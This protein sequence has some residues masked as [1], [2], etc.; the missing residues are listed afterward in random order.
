MNKKIKTYIKKQRAWLWM[1]LSMAVIATG[2]C[3][4]LFLVDM[5]NR[6]LPEEVLQHY[7][8]YVKNG[9]YDKMY[10]LLNEESKAFISQGDFVAKNKKI[11][12][13][14]EM[15][16]LEIVITEITEEERKEAH[17]RYETTMDT[18]VGQIYFPNKAIFTRN[19]EREYRLNW[20]PQLIFPRLNSD[21]KVRVNTLKGVRGTIYDRNG[22][23]LAGEGMAS[24]IGIVPGKMSEN[25]AYDIA[26]IAKLLDLPAESITK[27][28]GESYVKADTFVPIKVVSKGQ[29]ELESK[30]LAIKGIKIT[31]TPVR[32]YPLEEKIGHLVGYI[33]NVNAEDLEKLQGKDYNANSV[34]GRSGLEKIYE[35]TL[36]GIDG[37][38]IVIVDN[39]NQVK[40]TLAKQKERSEKDIILTIDSK[41][42]T[43]LYDQFS[44]D[45]SSAV[46]MNPKTG[47][48]LALVSTPSFDSNDFVLGMPTA[49]WEMLNNDVNKPLYNRFK[50]TL[51]PGSGFKSVIGA[52][53]L[54]T[55]KLH[56]N[57]NYGNSGL[58]WQ[59]DSSWGG[60]QVTTLKDYGPEVVLRNALIYSDN[61]YFAKAALKIGAD[62][63]KEQLLRLGFDE[64]IPFEVGLYSSSFSNTGKFDSEIQL[65]DS[66]YGQ[67]Q[68]LVNPIHM[69]SIYSAFINEGNMIKPYLIYTPTPT[70][71]YWKEQAFTKEAANIIRDD[72]IQVVEKAGKGLAKVEGMTLAGKTG[73]AEIKQSKD[74]Y[75]GTELGWFNVFTAD[76]DAKNPLLIISMV[77]DVKGRGGA[78]YVIPKVKKIFEH[79]K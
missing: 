20:Y 64:K 4:I 67:A 34:I 24:S 9:Q 49:K 47:E 61:I 48:V 16:N 27:K 73:T 70:P 56:P 55:G 77:E 74:D 57:D 32:V 6:M 60:Y 63:L 69:A 45:K 65:A 78:G 43:L 18:M 79:I 52:I 5:K 13:G 54:T 72:L 23:I 33:Q 75:E 7:M 40:E 50:A 17:I 44:K 39:K 51:C 2:I 42:Q 19:K 3:G 12:E 30:L 59:K 28:L 36:R 58:S 35:D 22:E 15:K 29:E 26:K 38:E 62:T 1:L 14:I 76:E 53:G 10:E 11:Y 46:A 8:D 21:D 37:Y 25:K 41:M 31:D 66:G 71:A 68:I